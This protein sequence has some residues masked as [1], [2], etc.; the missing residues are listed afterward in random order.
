MWG[1]YGQ[2]FFSWS[3]T[4]K[5]CIKHGRIR[6]IQI[7]FQ[8]VLISVPSIQSIFPVI[9]LLFCNQSAL[10]QLIGLC[11]GTQDLLWHLHSWNLPE[12]KVKKCNIN[13]KQKVQSFLSCFI[14]NS[15]KNSYLWEGTVH[16]KSTQLL[17]FFVSPQPT[18][19]FD[20][21][22]LYYLLKMVPEIREMII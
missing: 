7:P 18:S 20:C 13:K 21:C 4:I 6:E 5:K 19:V 12:N 1:R 16:K 22:F 3:H 2:D 15:K 8:N 9:L 17:R 10:I 14:N 11:K